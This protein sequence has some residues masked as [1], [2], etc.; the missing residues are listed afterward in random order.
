MTL[1]LHLLAFLGRHAA[2]FMAGGIFVGLALPGLA[3]WLRPLLPYFVFLL[4]AGTM[5]RIDG[6]EIIA[7][8]GRPWRLALVLLWGLV[9]SPIVTA[10]LVGRLGLPDGLAHAI[11]IWSA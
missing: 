6:P 2:R 10:G 5:I 9:L 1:P 4:A 3:A 11:V 8:V 7:H